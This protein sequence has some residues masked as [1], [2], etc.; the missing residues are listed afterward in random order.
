MVTSDKFLLL[1]MHHSTR[2]LSDEEVR[3]IADEAELLRFNAG[4]VVHRQNEVVTSLDLVITGRL[5]ISMVD[6]QG[7]ITVQR[8]QPAGGQYGVLSAALG[9]PAGVECVAEDPTTLLRLD[10]QMVLALSTK[11]QALRLNLLRMAAD[12]VKQFL[13]QHRHLVKPYLVAIFHEKPETRRLSR[14]LIQRLNELGENPCVLTDDPE[15]IP[16]EGLRYHLMRRN[17]RRTSEEETRRQISEW[18]DSQRVIADV[19]TTWEPAQADAL[20]GSCEL[21]LWCVTPQTWRE[22]LRKLEAFE[23]QAPTW[24]E[25][26][27]IVWLL[28]HEQAVPLASDLRKLARRDIK[29]SFTRPGSNRGP[30]MN[31][32]FERLVHLLRGVQI[33]VALGGGGARGMAHLGVL[34]AF[35]QNG[36]IIDMIAGSS[37]GAMTGTLYA[38][39]MDV[40]YTV[41][42]FIAD[43][44]PSWLF[45]LLPGGEQWYLLHK[46]RR[47]HFDPMLRRYLQRYWF[48]QISIPVHTVTVDLI[49]GKTVVREGGDAVDGVV[50]SINLPG[51]SL[52]ITR[53][54]QALI[55]GSIINTVPAD[56][57]VGKG[58]NYV[59]AVSLTAKLEPEFAN[60]R[61]D[62]PTAAMKHATTVQTLVRT[63]LVQSY[64]LDARG[65]Q[66]ADFVIEPDVAKFDLSAFT[67]TEEL[68]VA[69][70]QAT[71][72]V[73]SQIKE[74]LVRLDPQLFASFRE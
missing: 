11:Y 14:K 64:N 56:V 30:I 18:S 8:F 5:S 45:R 13:H 37:A 25:K 33:G 59:I 17:G 52:P 29:I 61:P 3:E 23:A 48:E 21:V 22:S 35:E 47:G 71:L 10:Y 68:A 39:G 41:E 16:I 49:S 40:D 42:R 12:G 50:E 69:G 46:Y 20:L 4:D 28:D 70:E 26:V 31:H 36:I 51:L 9:E 58:C 73:I 57:L 32:G 19:D 67:R 7:R 27:C 43:L 44:K 72:E 15:W 54:G 65:I 6:K 63:H 74:A 55:D 38:S 62:T 34:K 60:N 1:R 24:R 53:D 2:G 66:S